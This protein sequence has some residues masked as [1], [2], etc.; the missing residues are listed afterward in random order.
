MLDAE[1]WRRRAEEMRRIAGNLQVLAR[2]KASILRNAEEYH[3]QTRKAA[4]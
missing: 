2:A 4:T 1:H 3:R